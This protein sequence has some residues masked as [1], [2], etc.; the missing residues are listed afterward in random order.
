MSRANSPGREERSRFG[1]FRRDPGGHFLQG[2]HR[3]RTRQ[4]VVILVVAV[5]IVII[6]ALLASRPDDPQIELIDTDESAGVVALAAA[7]GTAPPAVTDNS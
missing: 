4:S 2:E 7:E 5:V 6:T 3:R 1:G